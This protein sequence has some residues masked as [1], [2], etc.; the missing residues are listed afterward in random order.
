M[1]FEPVKSS[2]ILGV[3]YNQA[4][5]ELEVIFRTG[6]KYRYKNVPLF[7]YEGLMNAKSQGQYMRKHI[8]DRYDFERMN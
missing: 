2:M 4:L 8:L 1:K 5:F 7:V 3:S 6:E